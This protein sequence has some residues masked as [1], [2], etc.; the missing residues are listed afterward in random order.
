MGSIDSR[1]SAQQWL[2]VDILD[3]NALNLDFDETVEALAKTDPKYIAIVC[4]SQQANVSAPIMVAVGQLCKKI[5]KRMPE[6]KLILTGWHPSALP[7]RT[8]RDEACD[9]LVKGEGFRTLVDLLAGKD[10]SQIPGLWWKHNE[11]ISHGA[12]PSNI[13]DLTMDLPDVA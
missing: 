12:E 8:L 9:I 2:D 4:Y 7:E 5:K 10:F 3:A 6:S 11:K 1:I 13:K